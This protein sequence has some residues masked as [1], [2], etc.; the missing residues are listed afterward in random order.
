MALLFPGLFFRMVLATTRTKGRNACA[1]PL[2][3]YNPDAGVKKNPDSY[4]QAG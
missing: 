1:A 2:L 3:A 4:D